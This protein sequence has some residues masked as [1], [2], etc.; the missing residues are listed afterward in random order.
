MKNDLQTMAK[1]GIQP[2]EVNQALIGLEIDANSDASVLRFFD[3]FTNNI[4]THA[5]Y[6]MHVLPDF[7][8]EKVLLERD[9]FRPGDQQVINESCV[10]EMKA[11][12]ISH[13][14]G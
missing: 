9:L 8:M 7:G 2:M 1:N 3:F 4:P 14:S 5:A 10:D 12:I 11:R 6:F 13:I